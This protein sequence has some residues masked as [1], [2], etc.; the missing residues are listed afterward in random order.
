[1]QTN[2]SKSLIVVALLSTLVAKS[3]V[4]TLYTPADN[5]TNV[6]NNVS[7]S[8]SDEFA[9]G[10]LS[11]ELQRATNSSFTSG[12]VTTNIS[13]TPNLLATLT[14][15]VTYYWRVRSFLGGS[16]YSSYSTI[17]SFTMAPSPVA[18]FTATP[19]TVCAGSQVSF[20]SSAST[21]TNYSWS[22]PGGTPSSSTAA[23]PTVTY[24]SIGVYNVTLTA[25][26]AMGS[27][28]MTKTNYISVVTN[29][30][31]TLSVTQ[32]NPIK[33][34]GDSVELTAGPSG[35]GYTY[36]W[37]NSSTTPSIKTT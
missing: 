4:P 14:A 23:N 35:A 32:G 28:V 22:F 19:T 36:L 34:P 8:W 13:G 1:M 30:T 9:S 6:L 2:L 5:A 21:A 33:C 12:L 31:P 37:S 29:F 11:Y 15:G 25:I 17:R 24:N 27:D 10:A 18:S 16:S 7:F 26:T 20:N 3:Q